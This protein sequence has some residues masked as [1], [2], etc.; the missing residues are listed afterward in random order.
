MWKLPGPGIEPMSP[1][2]AGGFLT[3]G[4]PGAS[5]TLAPCYSVTGK[6]Q[7]PREKCLRWE[8]RT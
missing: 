2:L 3:T 5:W 1:V 6:W 4:P 7:D 8:P